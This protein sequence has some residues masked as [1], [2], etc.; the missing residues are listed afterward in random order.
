MAKEKNIKQILELIV[1]N[2]DLKGSLMAEIVELM[3]SRNFV[4]ITTE[5]EGSFET[6]G[7]LNDY[8][9]AIDTL[10]EKYVEKGKMIQ[11]TYNES[12]NITRG[13]QRKLMLDH[14]VNL[15]RVKAL[16]HLMGLSLIN[17]FKHLDH[18]RS[19]GLST[20]KGGKVIFRINK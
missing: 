13:R 10:R 17:S 1:E 15:E 2:P 20:I 18:P 5:A 3:C 9:R 19:I 4:D 6:I 11:R 7:E 16:V 14:N 8:Q 12:K